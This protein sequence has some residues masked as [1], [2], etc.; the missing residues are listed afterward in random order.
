M[1]VVGGAAAVYVLMMLSALASTRA[2]RS[3]A[4]GAAYAGR[5]AE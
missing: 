1:I 5:K 4:S 3:G 2:D